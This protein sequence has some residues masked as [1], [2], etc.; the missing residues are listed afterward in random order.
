MISAVPS[1]D[2]QAI[3]WDFDGTL[4]R[5]PDMWCTSIAEACQLAGAL[6]VT[7]ADFDNTAYLYLPWNTEQLCHPHAESADLWWHAFLT[8]V[9]PLVAERVNPTVTDL[10]AV[11]D[12]VRK[13]AVDPRRYELVP[14]SAMAV[15]RIN[16]SGVPQYVLS[17]H[18]PELDEIVSHLFPDRFQDVWSSGRVG[19]EKPREEIFRYAL[20]RLP[21]P[22]DTVLMVG[23][24]YYRDLEPARTLGMQ[25]LH[26]SEVRSLR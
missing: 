13:L 1:S 2:Y 21:F 17:N 26:V 6:D 7:P 24:D 5:R 11:L 12:A 14:E 18:V 3:I 10:G 22:A 4:T 8:Q 20:N 9:R 23:D 19:F 25:I 15:T 16:A